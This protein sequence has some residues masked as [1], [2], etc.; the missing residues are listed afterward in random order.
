[1]IGK[2]GEILGALSCYMILAANIVSISNRQHISDLSLIAMW[3]A[4]H[5]VISRNIP[6]FETNGLIGYAIK[7]YQIKV[8]VSVWGSCQ[9]I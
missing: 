7:L 5:V 1:M 6:K 4:S 9:R 2:I 3:I 8:P